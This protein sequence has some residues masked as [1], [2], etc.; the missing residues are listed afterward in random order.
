MSTVPYRKLKGDAVLR[1]VEKLMNEDDVCGPEDGGI[2]LEVSFCL[3]ICWKSNARTWVNHQQSVLERMIQ[4][5]NVE[6]CWYRGPWQ[7]RS[8]A[9]IWWPSLCVIHP[10]SFLGRTIKR[11]HCWTTL[12]LLSSGSAWKRREWV[13]RLRVGLD[14]CSKLEQRATG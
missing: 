6:R 3:S 1:I 8:F 10:L 14:V 12:V 9:P 11:S 13:G 4:L 5:L 2:K 7:A